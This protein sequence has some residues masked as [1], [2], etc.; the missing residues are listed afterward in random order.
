MNA[1]PL[2]RRH[3]FPSEVISHCV[4]LYFRF[5]I[6]YRDVEEMMARRGLTLTYETIRYWCLKFGQTYA[7]GLRR[8]R[9]RPGD[10]WHL[11]EVFLKINGQVHYLWRAVDQDGD[12]LDILVQSRRDKKAAKKFFRKLLK[13]LRYVPRTI[14]TDKLRSYSAAIADVMPSVEHIHEKH[15]NNRAENS[16][17]PTRLRACDEK[18]QVIGTSAPGR[19]TSVQG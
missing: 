11:D 10:K 2:Y 16:H 4:W 3:R 18:I 15:Q 8:S 5:S 12:V 14:I 19:K 13:G 1:P 17:Q 7:N 6:S 9:P